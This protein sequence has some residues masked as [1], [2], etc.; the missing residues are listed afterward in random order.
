MN[1]AENVH[2]YTGKAETAKLQ[3]KQIREQKL[4]IQMHVYE[5]SSQKK[6]LQ[7]IELEE[8]FDYESEESVEMESESPGL[9]VHLTNTTQMRTP[10]RTIARECDRYQ[11][12]LSER[13]TAVITTAT[14]KD[15]AL[16]S[17]NDNTNV[18]DRHKV[19]RARAQ[20]RSEAMT[21][22]WNQD[23][24]TSLYFNG[25]KDVIL[26]QEKLEDSTYHRK[27]ITDE[28]IVLTAEPG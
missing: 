8:M 1:T 7:S 26:T 2:I 22:S 6:K 17:N 21:E 14:L 19:R 20:R 5:E 27:N 4:K 18:T 24:I 28:H 13:A 3:T 12:S 25:R 15:M 9:K 16:I 11:Y 23:D 10:L